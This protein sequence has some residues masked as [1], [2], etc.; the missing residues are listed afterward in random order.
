MM[1][2]ESSEL[3]C[4]VCNASL[5]FVVN[6]PFSI[7]PI[8]E[9]SL[10]SNGRQVLRHYCIAPKLDQDHA[11]QAFYGWLADSK[12]ASDLHRRSRRMSTTF[13]LFP[14]WLVRAR[15]AGSGET[16]LAIPAR[17]T[18]VRELTQVRLHPADLQPAN[19]EMWPSLAVPDIPLNALP[20]LLQEME[21]IGEPLEINLVHIPLF[22]IKYAY[23]QRLYTAMVDANNGSVFATLFPNPTT[24][25]YRRVVMITLLVY[26]SLS[27]L[28]VLAAYF[29]NNAFGIA[30]VIAVA[31]GVIST[32]PLFIVARRMV[33][34]R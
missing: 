25:S 16:T 20:R 10:Y 1:Q 28:P 4:V 22:T 19:A 13:G 3:V 29:G 33:A 6:N 15:M 21:M 17:A 2:N 9:T 11:E 26:A 27:L 24:R 32:I 30:L 23:Q 31:L 18:S 12:S 14:L 8:C 34:K 5:G 7:C